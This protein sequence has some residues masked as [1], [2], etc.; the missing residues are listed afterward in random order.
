M[1]HVPVSTSSHLFCCAKSG[2]FSNIESIQYMNFKKKKPNHHLGWG[3]PLYYPLNHTSVDDQLVMRSLLSKRTAISDWFLDSCW[4]TQSVI[5]N[6]LYSISHISIA[7]NGRTTPINAV[8]PGVT[9]HFART[10]DSIELIWLWSQSM[11]ITLVPTLL[12]FSRKSLMHFT[13]LSN[14][15]VSLLII[16][17]LPWAKASQL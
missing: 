1:C 12:V 13:S 10:L 9:S 15:I 5:T 16:P 8:M 17:S 14:S 6:L 2:F 4:Y 3:K 7:C 11:D